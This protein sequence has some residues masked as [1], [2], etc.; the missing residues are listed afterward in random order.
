MPAPFADVPALQ[1]TLLREDAS[2]IG[3]AS[4]DPDDLALGATVMASSSL[5]ELGAETLLER[6]PLSAD[7]GLVLPV[8]PGLTGLERLVDA[9]RDTELASSSTTRSSDRTTYPAASSTPSP[10]RSPPGR[11]SGSGRGSTGR[12]RAPATP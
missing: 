2:V 7:A 4:S 9:E 1:R 6:L 5:T 10:S 8:D 3:L 12:P 11:S